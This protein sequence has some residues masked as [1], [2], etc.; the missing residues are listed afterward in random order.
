[1]KI[2]ISYGE[3]KAKGFKVNAKGIE[4]FMESQM[5]EMDFAF[6]SDYMPYEYDDQGYRVFIVLPPID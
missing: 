6:L 3:I 2:C 4:Q 5:P 1:M